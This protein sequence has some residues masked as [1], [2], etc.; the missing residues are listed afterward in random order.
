MNRPTRIRTVSNIA[1]PIPSL[2]NSSEMKSEK[3][4]C[5]RRAIRPITRAMMTMTPLLWPR[6]LVA[7]RIPKMIAKTSKKGKMKS[8]TPRF[9]H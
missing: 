9:S 2:G 4:Y 1:M 3:R 6:T 7:F 5:Q 8:N